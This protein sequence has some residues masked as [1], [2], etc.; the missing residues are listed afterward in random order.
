[1]NFPGH[2]F[3]AQSFVYTDAKCL[4]QKDELMQARPL[5]AH[6]EDDLGIESRR[7]LAVCADPEDGPRCTLRQTDRPGHH[8]MYARTVARSDSTGKTR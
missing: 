4:Y 7:V 2:R 1:M 5:Q 3:A 8:L 6:T